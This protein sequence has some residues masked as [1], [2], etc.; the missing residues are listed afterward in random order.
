MQAKLQEQLSPADA[1][2]ILGRLPERAATIEMAIASFL[3]T[4]ALGFVDCKPGRG[5]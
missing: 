5:Q 2:V 4:E 3:D 1:E